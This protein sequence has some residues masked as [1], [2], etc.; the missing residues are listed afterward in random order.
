MRGA[1]VL[2]YLTTT[3]AQSEARRSPG[4]VEVYGESVE[5]PSRFEMGAM[6]WTLDDVDTQNALEHGRGAHGPDCD[7]RCAEQTYARWSAAGVQ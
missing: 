4:T 5:L 1:G 3:R 7:G 6:A 2:A